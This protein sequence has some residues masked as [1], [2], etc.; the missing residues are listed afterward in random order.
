MTYSPYV[1]GPEYA[2]PMEHSHDYDDIAELLQRANLPL[3]SLNV[4][5]SDLP[6]AYASADP[7]APPPHI[8]AT[9]SWHQDS[10][11]Y[12]A[13]QLNTSDMIDV[14]THLGVNTTV[15]KLYLAGNNVALT[16]EVMPVLARSMRTNT[17]LTI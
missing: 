8:V 16:D 12:I 2:L 4:D 3:V 13:E 14:L 7:L 11:S 15:R 9:H 6:P 17:T 1:I 10:V 5:R